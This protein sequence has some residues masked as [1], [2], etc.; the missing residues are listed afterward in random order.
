MTITANAENGAPSL[1]GDQFPA[2]MQIFLQ[3]HI[4]SKLQSAA[5]EEHGLLLKKYPA[6]LEKMFMGR[7]KFQYNEKNFVRI[8]NNFLVEGST[9]IY[10]LCSCRR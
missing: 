1:I 4:L 2:A 5:P 3:R 9:G 6:E 8:R 10:C 7:I